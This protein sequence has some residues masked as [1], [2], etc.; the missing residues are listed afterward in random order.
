MRI[1]LIVCTALLMGVS[2]N[3]L[4]SA[5]AF[6]NES[7]VE[8]AFD[9]GINPQDL[10]NWMKVMAAAPNQVGSP[11]DKSNAEYELSLFKKWGWDAR[12]ETFQVLYP[13]PQ[14]EVLETV[15]PNPFKATLTEHP[16]AG[17]P[18]TSQTNG[19]LPAYLAYAADGDVTAELVYVNY[20]TEDDYKTLKRLGVS[21][22]GKIAIARYGAVWRGVKPELA[23]KHGAIGC[24][25]YSD[26]QDDGYALGAVY[27]DGPMR[28][29]QGIQRGSAMDMMLYP[30]DPLT[31]GVGAVEGAKRLPIADAATIQKIPALPISYGDAQVLLSR[32][33]GQVAPRSWRGNLPVTYRVSGGP[34]THL[35]LRSNWGLKPVYDVIATIQGST[36]PDQWIVRANHHD[37]WVY[38]ASDPMAGQVGL[39]AE[40]QSIGRLIKQGWRPK[41]TLVYASWDGEEPMLLGSTEWAETH[42]AELKQKAVL[43]INTDENMRGTLEANGNGDLSHFITSAANDVIDPETGTSVGDRVRAKMRINLF[44]GNR[45][46]DADAGL[47]ETLAQPNADFPLHPLGS[48]SDYST[49]VDHLGLATVDLRFNGET[50]NEGVYHSSYDTFYH[51]S[52]FVDPG[53]VY[54]ALLPKVTGRLVLRAAQEDVPIQNPLGLA[55]AV[56][57]YLSQVK[58]LA[59]R[60]RE[61]ATVEQG[62]IKDHAFQ[63]AAD[64]KKPSGLPLPLSPV[65][66]LD[67]SAMDTAVQRLESSA[68]TYQTALLSRGGALKQAQRDKL[69][70]LMLTVDETLTSDAGLPDRPWYRNLIYAPGR[71]VGYGAKT[72]PGIRE[73]VENERWNDAQRYIKLTADA[74]NA[75]SARLD[76]ANKVLGP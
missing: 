53:F 6:Q 9:K 62:L 11:H 14:S 37:G 74:L 46:G 48:G 38:G 47:A 59:Q 13:T 2:V 39:M 66:P 64:P 33:T 31:P 27:P 19:A 70:A 73:S 23:Y 12:I 68:N 54:D 10:E 44:D 1:P 29:A 69:L 41:R 3:A 56:K 65:P 52:K 18:T 50:T 42:A 17:D 63:A 60:M 58:Q 28:P 67:F 7:D 34:V 72:I 21:V 20:G 43:Y 40:V 55:N 16:I 5:S 76:E 30:G 71:Y 75:Y 22:K 57:G 61:R 8:K 32:F 35:A 26:P 51:H 15:G 36:Y 24:I 25:I 4:A 49:F 45:G